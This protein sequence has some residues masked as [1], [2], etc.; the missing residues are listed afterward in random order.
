MNVF[1]L[2]VPPSANLSRRYP[3][4]NSSGKKRERDE[5]I[6]LL[7]KEEALSLFIAFTTYGERDERKGFDVYACLSYDDSRRCLDHPRQIVSGRETFFI[8][9]V[10]IDRIKKDTIAKQKLR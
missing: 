4:R 7:H 10:A 8:S 1:L 2:F 9:C 5:T 3:S 6:E